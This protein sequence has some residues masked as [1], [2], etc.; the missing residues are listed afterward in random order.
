MMAI[1]FSSFLG[2]EK[3]HTVKTLLG[4]KPLLLIVV[5]AAI[6]LTAPNAEAQSPMQLAIAKSQAMASVGF[7][8]LRTP[9]KSPYSTAPIGMYHIAPQIQPRFTRAEGVGFSP[10]SAEQAIRNAC[11]FGQRPI[12]AY[13]VVLGNDGYYATVYYR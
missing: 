4:R 10:I 13:A 11:H 9:Y 2:N 12:V 7:D 1:L 3:M 8:Q 6:Q 5:A